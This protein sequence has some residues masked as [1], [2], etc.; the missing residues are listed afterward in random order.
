MFILNHVKPEEA[1]G[2][3]AEAYSV[4]PPGVPVPDPLVLM[5]ASPELTR[6]QVEIIRHYMGHEKLDIGL[7]AMI[8]YLVALEFDYTF[9][10][11]FNGGLLKMAG[12]MS[13]ADLE[14]L[15][16]DPKNAPLE[17]SQKE[18]L[19]FVLKV[20]KSPEDVSTDD[21]E[22]LRQ[23]GWSDE[24]IFDAAFHGASMA[25]PSILYKAFKKS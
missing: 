22:K 18:M 14:N 24:H 8:R 21:I 6:L 4:I 20:V 10:I 2:K 5:S 12:G 13:D 7:L 3:V 15:K 11:D 17:E 19:L 25:A 9:C 23:Y 16:A 1:T